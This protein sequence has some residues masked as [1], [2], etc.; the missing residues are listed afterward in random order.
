MFWNK[1]RPHFAQDRIKKLEDDLF[2]T[3]SK[4][5]SLQIVVG[6]MQ[7]VGKRRMSADDLH[8]GMTAWREIDHVLYRGTIK[9]IMVSGFQKW[10]YA[11]YGPWGLISFDIDE[12]VWWVEYKPK[13]KKK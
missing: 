2:R 5:H 3:K 6:E 10:A 7:R 4:L 1:I 8:D 11:C 9:R 12:Q 13:A